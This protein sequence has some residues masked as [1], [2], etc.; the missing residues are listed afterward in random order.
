MILLSSMDEP[1]DRGKDGHDSNHS[2]RVIWL[3]TVAVSKFHHVYS[4]EREKF[5]S[6]REFT[7]SY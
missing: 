2:R 7:H 1:I 3:E 5:P 6:W 4:N